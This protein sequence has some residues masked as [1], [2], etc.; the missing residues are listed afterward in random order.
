MNI[1]LRFALSAVIVLAALTVAAC[2]AP[3]PEHL[4]R[5][6]R[7]VPA[8]Y[9]FGTIFVPLYQQAMADSNWAPIR[10]QL[11]DIERLKNA[12]TALDV[13]ENRILARREWERNQTLFARGVGYLNVALG[14]SGTG[15]EPTAEQQEEIFKGLHGAYDWW[16]ELVKFLR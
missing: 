7:K 12:V 1:R 9:E 6:S 8:L 15:A 16:A 14:E 4:L 13:P 5:K 3:G 2:G 10:E 11:R